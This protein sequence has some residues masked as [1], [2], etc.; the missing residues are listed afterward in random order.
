MCT[1]CHSCGS[2]LVKL[3]NG[4][5]VNGNDSFLKLDSGTNLLSCKVCGETQLSSHMIPVISPTISL[6]SSDSSLS[7]SSKC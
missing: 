1:M 7:N 5:K 6:T 3:E 2:E 4:E